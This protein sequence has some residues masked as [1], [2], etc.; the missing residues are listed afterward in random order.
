MTDPKDPEAQNEELDVEELKGAAGGLGGLCGPG[1]TSIPQDEHRW[2]CEPRWRRH[3]TAA[4]AHR[5]CSEE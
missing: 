1:G 3:M 5:L 4:K 2:Q